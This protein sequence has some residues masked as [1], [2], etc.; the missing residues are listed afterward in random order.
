MDIDKSYIR[1]N[2][3]E[4]SNIKIESLN[5]SHCDVLSRYISYDTKLHKFLSPNL[6]QTFVNAQDYYNECKKWE[7]SKN[8]KTFT[9][10]YKDSIIGSISYAVESNN[11]DAVSVGMWLA[12]EFWNNH[13][14]TI[15]LLKFL[16]LLKRNSFKK[17]L[18]KVRLDNPRSISMCRK[19]NAS[20]A[21]DNE[22]YYPFWDLK[23]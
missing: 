2:L 14:G 15:T 20:I 5:I 21:K 11:I 9:I 4:Y 16:E 18:G 23:K 17:A 1:E 19:L 13:L 8:G 22:F 10:F 7:R 3:E 6:D 12:S